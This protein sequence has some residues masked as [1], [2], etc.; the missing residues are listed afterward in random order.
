MA[1]TGSD[2]KTD[3]NIKSPSQIYC[4]IIAYTVDK[5]GDE[6]KFTPYKNVGMVTCNTDDNMGDC[7]NAQIGGRIATTATVVDGVVAP[8]W[9]SLTSTNYADYVFGVRNSLT[10]YA[11][12]SRLESKDSIVWG[13]YGNN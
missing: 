9:V 6:Y 13:D 2:S 4:D 1:R 8:T 3:R 11:G 10:E 5:D 12:A 7:A